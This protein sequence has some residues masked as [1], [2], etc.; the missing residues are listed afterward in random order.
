MLS[1][2]AYE[3]RTTGCPFCDFDIC[4]QCW[5]EEGRCD[6]EAP[7]THPVVYRNESAPIPCCRRING[8]VPDSYTQHITCNQCQVVCKGVY[9]RTDI[10]LC[11]LQLT[12]RFQIAAIVPEIT[13][14]CASS[15]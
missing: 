10:R 15:A 12:D 8:T 13:S 1:P 11:V 3:I 7:S 2:V 5:R 14:T 6:S 9:F 4:D